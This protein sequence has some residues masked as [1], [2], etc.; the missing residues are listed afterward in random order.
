MASII[1]EKKKIPGIKTDCIP[2]ARNRRVIERRSDGFIA[3]RKWVSCLEILG[4]TNAKISF[5]KPRNNSSP[6][7]LLNYA[8]PI[9]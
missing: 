2:V 1:F 4:P 5:N 6:K 3:L 7:Y 9:D 8:F